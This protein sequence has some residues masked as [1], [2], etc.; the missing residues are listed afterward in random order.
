MVTITNLDS[1][2]LP[3]KNRLQSPI[4]LASETNTG[5][6]RQEMRWTNLGSRIPVADGILLIPLMSS[7]T[8][9]KP[10]KPWIFFPLPDLVG[11]QGS[12]SWLEWVRAGPGD[13]V[14]GSHPWVSSCLTRWPW[15]VCLRPFRFQFVSYK[16]T[17]DCI[18][19]LM[20][21]GEILP[22]SVWK[23]FT[24]RIKHSGILG[25]VLSWGLY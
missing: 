18:L 6:K 22:T 4:P 13:R 8:Q 5:G 24:S 3:R 23:A 19:R 21:L 16:T 14:L 12:H 7:Q 15:P 1:F 9:S 20:A 10:I 11:S 17:D 25:S 2:S